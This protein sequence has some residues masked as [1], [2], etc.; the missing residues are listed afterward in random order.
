[1]LLAY[2]FRVFFLAA[3]AL[4]A[5]VGLVWAASLYGVAG[6]AAIGVAAHAHEMVFGFGGAVV[7]GFVLTAVPRWTSTPRVHGAPLLALAL[8]W[9]LA[10]AAPWLG[11]APALLFHAA[12]AL[13][14]PGVALAVGVPIVRA[15]SRRNYG[16][17]AIL[18]GLGA[19]AATSHAALL[20]WVSVAPSRP[21]A[22]AAWALGLLVMVIG[23]RVTPLFT[24]NALARAGSPATVRARDRRD[25]V[26]LGAAVAAVL[27]SVTP[28]PDVVVA[29]AFLVAAGAAAGRMWG[30][31]TLAAARD[32]LVFVLHTG[33]AW[34]AVALALRGVAALAP[35]QV[36]PPLAL[37]ALTVGGIGTYTLGMMARVALGHTGRELRAPP[38]AT[39]AFVL[40]HGA[41][42]VRLLAPAS[43]L[44]AA[45]LLWAAAFGLYLLVYTPILTSPRADGAPG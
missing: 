36:P 9:T 31:G 25:D 11:G 32:P 18:V 34:V 24:K 38:L 29:A 44:P 13:F 30:W 39:V 19:L 17:L 37:H 43:A 3:A 14:L 6:P 2:G 33:Y 35:A 21:A 41:A 20:G 45:A 15:R 27:A 28:L 26:A 4:A 12:G 8:L 23:G 22:T 5:A 40:L 16:V 10:R 42:L 1:V 7:A